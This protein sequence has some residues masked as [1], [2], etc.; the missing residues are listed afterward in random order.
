MRVL[1]D[2]RPALRERSGA[3]EYTH[4]L[5]KALLAVFPPGGPAPALELS[6]FSSSWKDRLAPAADLAGAAI[7]DRRVP[8]RLLNL[9]WHR[10]G[11]PPAETIAGGAYDVT[12]SSHPLL[13]PARTA[14]Q[15]VTIHDL[16]FL[17]HPERTRAEV[18]RDYPALA[19][20]HAHRA[21]AILVPSAYTAGEV[22]RV[23]GVPRDRLAIC[24]PGAPDWTARPAAPKAGYVLFFSTLEPRK[25]VV[26]LLDAYERLIGSP[27]RLALPSDGARGFQPSVPELVLAGKATED[28]RV[29]LDRLERPPLKGV[30]RYIG[31][32]DPDKRRA[33]YDGARLLVQ[34]SFD[35]GFG[36]PVLEA[37]SLGVPVVAA[38]RGSLPEVVGDAGPLVDPEQPADIANAIAH[39]LFDDAYAATCVSRGLIRARAF[40][41]DQTAR[42]VFD[43]YRRAIERRAQRTPA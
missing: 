8:V 31:Y 27:E 33:L 43:A 25:N 1:I 7:V 19:R 28:A 15:V 18:R 34:P 9:S 12:H 40:R 35:E 22:E 16:D 3:G 4:E 32:V 26:G 20:D 29:W 6:L 17:S 42:R 5:V 36:M 10:L 24:P 38:N 13:L 39:V 30:V 37:M 11:W 23:L 21:D 41:W 2:Y 14:A